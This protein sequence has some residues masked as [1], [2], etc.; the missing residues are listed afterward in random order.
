M[1]SKDNKNEEEENIKINPTKKAGFFKRIYI[2][3]FKVEKYGEFVLEKTSVAIK[4]FFALVLLVAI[5]LALA[6]TIKTYTIIDK[7]FNYLRNEMPDFKL[8]NG[9]VIFDQDTTAYD[10]DLDFYVLYHTSSDVT[11]DSAKE[12]EKDIKNYST[13]IIYLRDRIIYYNGEN[14]SYFKYQDLID[15]YELNISNKQDLL[16][17]AEKT[18]PF[19]VAV[20]YFVVSFIS[21][22]IVNIVSIFFDVLLIYCFGIITAKLCGVNIPWSKIF[23]LAIYSLTLSI[24][25]TLVYTSVY[26]FINFYIKYFDVVY[27][28]IAYIY[29]ISAIL[30]I[31]SDVIK[32][33]LELQKIVEV[34]KEVKKEIEEEKEKEEKD[35]KDKE[36]EKDKKREDKEGEEED[37]V[38][39][40]E[41]DGSE[42]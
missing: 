20:I 35:K 27:L 19:S 42:I 40:R 5:I 36:D 39:D 12:I 26:T 37:P 17:L 3:V 38:L 2:S 6:T 25:L 13:A 22:Y 8:S 31:K 11:D 7:G 33:N 28:L 21:M 15:Q 23:T 10:K 41:P 16:D 18:G 14:Y 24:L 9:T 4:Y 1:E 34:Q 29:L 30:I 32:Q